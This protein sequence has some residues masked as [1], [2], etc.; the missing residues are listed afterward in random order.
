LDFLDNG[1]KGIGTEGGYRIDTDAGTHR[2]IFCKPSQMFQ[3]HYRILIVWTTFSPTKGRGVRC[4]KK[5]NKKQN[6]TKVLLHDFVVHFALHNKVKSCRLSLCVSAFLWKNV[7]VIEDG[8]IS[9]NELQANDSS[10]LLKI[11]KK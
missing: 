3:V 5:A 7:M 2:D 4:K 9:G 11:K 1:M 8:A 10:L 6:K